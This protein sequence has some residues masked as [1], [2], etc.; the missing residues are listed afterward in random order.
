[1]Y[2]RT[3]LFFAFIFLAFIAFSQDSIVSLQMKEGRLEGSLLLANK[4]QKSPVVLIIAGS[5]ATDRDGNQSE[6]ENN[7]LKLLA[8]NLQKN[9]ISSLRFDK[10]GIGESKEALV[11]ERGLKIETFVNDVKA[12]IR[13]LNKSQLFSKIIIAGHS[14]G[15]LIGLLASE[16][17]KDVAAYVSIAG[18]GRPA[19]EILKEQFIKTPDEIKNIIFPLLDKLKKGDSIPNVPPI[20]YSL[21]R[22]SV[23]GY[24]T[25]WFKYNPAEEIKK[26]KVPILIIQGKTDIQVKTIDAE[27]LSKNLPN[28]K[29]VLIDNMNHVLKFCEFTEKEK[30]MEIYSNPDLE[31]HP[32]LMPEI[33]SFIN[34]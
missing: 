2:S 29:L 17:N 24:M 32:A 9:G 16:K 27:L 10:R 33:I 15:A 8:Q 7:S 13:F 20:L 1:L 28:A 25:S 30:Q 3:Q 22:P 34:K 6:L 14:E 5:G 18:A 21:F 19:D 31:L 11:S 12:W 26:L 23:Q 4:K